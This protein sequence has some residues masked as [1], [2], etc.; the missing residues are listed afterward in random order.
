[1]QL[2]RHNADKL[3]SKLKGLEGA[4]LKAPKASGRRGDGHASRPAIS[5]QQC[6][7]CQRGFSVATPG[8]LQLEAVAGTP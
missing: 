3:D 5:L 1:M 7:F 4:F 6:L 8:A 2:S